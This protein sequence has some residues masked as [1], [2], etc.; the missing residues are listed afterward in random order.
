MH[1]FSDQGIEKRSN[2]AG[3]HTFDVVCYHAVVLSKTSD[4]RFDRPSVDQM[5]DRPAMPNLRSPTPCPL[6]AL[7]ARQSRL[8]ASPPLGTRRYNAC[9]ISNSAA[10]PFTDFST[11]PK[12]CSASCSTHN[13]KVFFLT[14]GSKIT[15]RTNEF[16]IETLTTKLD[17][18]P[19][20]RQTNEGILQIGMSFSVRRTPAGVPSPEVSSGTSRAYEVE[21]SSYPSLILPDAPARPEESGARKYGGGVN[22]TQHARLPRMN[23]FS[24][25]AGNIGALAGLRRPERE[26]PLFSAILDACEGT[27]KDGTVPPELALT[28]DN[29]AGPRVYLQGPQIFGRMAELIENAD[30]EVLLQSY[31]WEADSGAAQTIMTALKRLEARKRTEGATEPVRVRIAVNELSPIANKILARSSEDPPARIALE[32][33]LR[34][35]GLDPS[36]VEVEV[37]GYRHLSTGSMHS[38]S[39]VVDG[40]IGMLTGANVQRANDGPPPSNDAA[41]EV[42][43][44][45]ALGLRADFAD[46]W[47]SIRGVLLP[48][49]QTSPLYISEGVSMLLANRRA[50]GY[51]AS[52]RTANPQDRAFL[53]IFD[54]AQQRIRIITPNF[55]DDDA[56][57]GLLRAIR[58]GVKVEMVLSKGFN[59]RMESK[60][61][62]GGTNEQVVAA[63][64]RELE[65]NGP[66]NWRELLDVRWYS[67]DGV[68]PVEGHAW[69]KNH[70]KYMSADGQVAATGSA[71]MDS[72]SW[73]HSRELNVVIDSV[74]T[75]RAW[76]AQVFENAFAMGIRAAG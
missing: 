26:S 38:K 76:D 46:A 42:V 7:N 20:S 55:N 48:E 51:L 30:R 13:P 27:W 5:A 21:P 71:N 70:T 9:S 69:G 64:V 34:E 47:K 39:L 22:T 28:H 37:A 61:M 1:V 29:I 33:Q 31:E 41:F 58:R 67:R 18:G 17:D 72:Q 14:P 66:A 40:R 32:Q 11:F 54:N 50:N 43:G 60:P 59:D 6:F 2:I 15:S 36:L 8:Q 63:L 35:A 3:R 53:A 19:G 4:H 68:D 62:Q 65:K 16:I 74:E 75:T 49:M 57:R 52:N 45:V 24:L 10:E 73:N 44:E 56:K 25:R 23:I 12:R